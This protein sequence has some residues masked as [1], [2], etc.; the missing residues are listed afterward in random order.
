M[1]YYNNFMP[2]GTVFEDIWL[3]YENQQGTIQKRL[4]HS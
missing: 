2:L 4:E 1:Q 3:H